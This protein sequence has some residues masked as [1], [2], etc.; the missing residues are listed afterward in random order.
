MTH[1]ERGRNGEREEE[2]PFRSEYRDRVAEFL[3][4]ARSR[5]RAR[6]SA[7]G[8]V[9]P[10]A[11]ARDSGLHRTNPLSR[12]RSWGSR[13]SILIVSREPLARLQYASRVHEV[14]TLAW[15]FR[16]E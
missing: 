12:W 8:K 14:N 3:G 10:E 7:E 15:Q 4:R 2:K 13:K 11:K 9:A 1:R 6:P 5:A 16:V